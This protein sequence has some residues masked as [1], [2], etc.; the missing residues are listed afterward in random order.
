MYVVYQLRRVRDRD[1]AVVLEY[2]GSMGDGL[3]RCDELDPCSTDGMR[4]DLLATVA[5]WGYAV[6]DTTGVKLAA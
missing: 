4:C 6:V 5:G 3:D 2:A 1:T